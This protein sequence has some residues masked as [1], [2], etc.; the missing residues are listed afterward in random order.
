MKTHFL[1]VLILLN[2]LSAQVRV[3]TFQCG[4][5]KRSFRVVA[6]DVKYQKAVDSM[7]ARI[8]YDGL[9]CESGI[10]LEDLTWS[11][12]DFVLAIEFRS[13]FRMYD[14]YGLYLF[15]I[16]NGTMIEKSSMGLELFFTPSGLW[17]FYEQYWFP[18]IKPQLDTFRFSEEYGLVPECNEFS[19]KWFFTD[20]SLVL[21]TLQSREYAG[22][23]CR[24]PGLWYRVEVPIDTAVTYMNGLGRSLISDVKF[25]EMNFAQQILMSDAVEHL[26]VPLYVVH[27]GW[28]NRFQMV[29]AIYPDSVVRGVCKYKVTNAV[30]MGQIYENPRYLYGKYRGHHLVLEETIHGKKS[31]TWDICWSRVEKPGSCPNKTCTNRVGGTSTILKDNRRTD[32]NEITVLKMNSRMTKH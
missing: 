10:H 14:N 5:K 9:T 18:G 31:G 20:S 24:S 30:D 1:L 23:P 13:L 15:N 3:E 25:H 4:P 21:Q 26:K 6:E 2:T 19:Y 16:E 32:W 29:V 17:Q 28:D 7:N 11:V 22:G 12:A 27:G 8:K